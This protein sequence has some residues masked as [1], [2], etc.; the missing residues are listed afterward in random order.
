MR[1]KTNAAHLAGGR[2]HSCCTRMPN[3]SGRLIVLRLEVL[4]NF[5]KT[6]EPPPSGADGLRAL[7]LH[8]KPRIGA[9]WPCDTNLE[10]MRRGLRALALPANREP[11][12]IGPASLI[13]MMEPS[14][15]HC[16]GCAV[17]LIT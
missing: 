2:D 10:T 14:S 1:L 9:H 8:H 4:R 17:I 5:E 7:T 3:A 15:L 6:S 13:L 12:R 16:A 11:V